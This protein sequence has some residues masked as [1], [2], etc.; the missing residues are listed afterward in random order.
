MPAKILYL[1]ADF[2][3][4]QVQKPPAYR[5]DMFAVVLSWQTSTQRSDE[6]RCF[7]ARLM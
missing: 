4:I 3:G 1:Q 6:I 2:S 5:S 7:A